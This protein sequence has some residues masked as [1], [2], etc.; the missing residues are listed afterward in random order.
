MSF[1]GRLARAIADADSLLCVGLDP[2]IERCPDVASMEAECRGLLEACLPSAAAVKPN[3]AFF[4]QYGPDGLA[5]LTRLREAVPAEKVFLVDAK[6]G[7]V[8]STAAA[9]ARALFDR[10]GADAVTANPLMGEDAVRPFLDRPGK[11]CFLVARSSNPGAAD[12]LEQPLAD[13]TA[14]YE[15]IADLARR[16]D[17]LGNAGLVVG[18]TAP[19]AVRAV[20]RRAPGMPLLVPGVG[21]QGGALEE[22]VEAALDEGRGG[23][24]VAVSRGISLAPDPGAA[25]AELAR[26][27]RAVRDARPVAG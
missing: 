10:L 26:R 1:A 19:D 27:M 24:L 7:D 20:R 13:G 23:V 18:A 15:R 22:A 17:R 4:E 14:V 16:W 8:G 3:V 21:A 5:V 9:Y 6:R 11:G 12:L 25:A 2:D